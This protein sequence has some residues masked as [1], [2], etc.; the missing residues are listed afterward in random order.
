MEKVL[1]IGH[2][3]THHFGLF[4]DLQSDGRAIVRYSRLRPIN[5][6]FLLI[7]RRFHLNKKINRIIDLPY[8]YFWYDFHDVLSLVS[9]IRHIMVIDI[10]MKDPVTLDVINKCRSKKPKLEISLFYLNAI[11]SNEKNKRLIFI[12]TIDNINKFE[13]DVKYTF[14]IGDSKRYGMKYMGF[15][16]YSKHSIKSINNPKYDL[17]YIGRSSLD[18]NDLFYAVY[19]KLM[20]EK[21]KLDFYI[22]PTIVEENRLTDINYIDN[23]TLQYDEILEELQN[24]KCILEILREKQVGP[25]LRYFEAVCY[26]KKLLTTNPEIVNFPY[27]DK[28][29]MRYFSNPDDIDVEWLKDDTCIVDYHYKGDFSP[30]TLINQLVDD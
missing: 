1:I 18:R 17:Y 23:G 9:R 6:K 22:K 21:C 29:Y 8:K 30:V 5:N 15:N 2:K 24:S 16:Y 25:S 13:F 11:G 28:R 27:Y 20:S 4:D 26:N 10:A 12:D 19:N 3:F 7:L 14:D